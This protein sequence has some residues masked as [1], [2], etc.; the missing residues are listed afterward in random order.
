MCTYAD[1]SEI[2][3]KRKKRIRACRKERKADTELALFGRK[4]RVNVCPCKLRWGDV[5]MKV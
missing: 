5:G 2:K 3:R 4:S 1:C